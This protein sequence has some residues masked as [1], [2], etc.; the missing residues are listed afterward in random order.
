MFVVDL[1]RFREES[2]GDTIRQHYGGLA[3]TPNSLQNM[4]QDLPNSLQHVLPIH[5][6]PQEW[7]WCDSWCGPQSKER[8]KI[9][10]L[11]RR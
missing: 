4:D 11:V 1:K 3:P 8:A 6:L 7:L 9:I 5:P 10:D 2:A